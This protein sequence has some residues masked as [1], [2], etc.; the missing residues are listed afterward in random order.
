M[1]TKTHKPHHQQFNL[2][3]HQINTLLC[4]IKLL[5]T[6]FIKVPNTIW[7]WDQVQ[8]CYFVI[9]RWG[10]FVEGM[11]FIVW[12]TSEFLFC[13]RSSQLKTRARFLHRSCM[14]QAK[15]SYPLVLWIRASR[16]NVVL[17]GLL[18]IP[19]QSDQEVWILDFQK[20]GVNLIHYPKSRHSMSVVKWLVIFPC[21][22]RAI[23]AKIL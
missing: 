18:I 8:G 5:P 1:H 21:S 9:I 10:L 16:Q 12:F 15:T 4:I 19:A 23:Q 3:W 14:D 13:L 22:L 17:V 6:N 7:R 20:G 2:T 11:L